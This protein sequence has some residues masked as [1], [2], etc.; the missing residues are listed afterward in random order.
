MRKGSTCEAKLIIRC[1]IGWRI[2]T[3]REGATC[4][5]KL[6]ITKGWLV[7]QIIAQKPFRR[8]FNMQTHQPPPTDRQ[9]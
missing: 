6:I 4:E 8:E 3:L 2:M 9:T 7:G 5:T 1:Y